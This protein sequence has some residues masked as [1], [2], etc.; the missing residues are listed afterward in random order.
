MRPLMVSVNICERF[1][2]L[3]EP[4]RGKMFANRGYYLEDS[5]KSCRP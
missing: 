5:Y 2:A 1:D 3:A 4:A